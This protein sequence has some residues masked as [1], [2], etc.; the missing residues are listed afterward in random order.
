VPLASCDGPASTLDPAGPAAA[1][2]ATLWWLMLAG[3]AVLFGLVVTLLVVA[4]GRRRP[5]RESTRLWLLGGGVILPSLILPVLL[6]YAIAA[7]ER[8]LPHGSSQVEIAVIA[9]QWDWTFLYRRDSSEPRVS[10]GV[11]HMPAGRSV[12]FHVTSGDVIHSFWVPRLG[13]KIDAIP[14]RT[15]VHRLMAAEPGR[16]L[17]LCAEFCGTGHTQM[18]VTVEVHAEDDY[19]QA[20]DALEAASP[21]DLARAA[22]RLRE[23]WR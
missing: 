11:L 17:G 19:A 4:L 10:N 5:A 22:P 13:G 15:T 6:A 9:R 2:I 12:D 23:R 1:S 18:M 3:A 7:G 8:L 20:V 14:G 16:L 21:G